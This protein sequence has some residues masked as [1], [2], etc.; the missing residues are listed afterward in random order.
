[1]KLKKLFIVMIFVLSLT[2]CEL[3]YY[4]PNNEYENVENKQEQESTIDQ[5]KVSV[6]NN[7]NYSGVINYAPSVQL[8][9]SPQEIYKQGVT[10]TVYIIA[11]NKEVVYLGSGVVFSE[12]ST[13]DGYAYIFTNAHVIQD[14]T[15]IEVVYSN[16]KRD[17][18]EVVGYHLLED[19]AVIAVRKNNNYTVATINTSNNLTTASN[20]L[21]I[22]TPM[23]TDFSFTATQGIISKI[24]SPLS[25]TLDPNYTLLLLQIDAS[26]NQGNSGGPLFD[27]YGNLIGL[28]TMKVVHDENLNTVDDLNFAIPMERAV[29]IANKFF[30]NQKYERGLLG[31]TIMDI[32]DISLAQRDMDNINL[33]HGLFVIEV[34][35]TGASNN[36]IHPNDI[37]T[38][39]NNVEFINKNE[40][41][42]E[43]FNHSKGEKVTLTIYRNKQYH[44]FTI[45]LK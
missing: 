17:N 24:D 23:S 44:T 14:T 18:A 30:D 20:V 8:E 12:D 39:I 11:S 25:S 37:I 43:L 31:V 6:I 26:L 29:F 9:Q 28:N 5:S 38:K 35:P 13:N 10:S 34:S 2:G 27:C 42:K 22:G 33:E 15:N 3:K 21:A 36:L 7:W 16:Y 40:F 41:Q 32:V 45:T 19:I 4:T 1:M